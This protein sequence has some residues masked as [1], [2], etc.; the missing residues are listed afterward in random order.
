MFNLGQLRMRLL[1][2]F[3]ECQ[4]SFTAPAAEHGFDEGH[5]TDL[6]TQELVAFEQNGLSYLIKRSV[7]RHVP[8]KE[9]PTSFGNRGL[10][11]SNL[12]ILPSLK[13]RSIL[14]SHSCGVCCNASRMGCII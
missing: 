3:L 11:A 5:Q 6:L 9:E 4:R 2:D 7:I 14:R 8:Y 1:C 12:P 13:A 10:R